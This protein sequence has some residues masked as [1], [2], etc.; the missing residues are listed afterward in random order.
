MT[1]PYVI[2]LWSPNPISP[3][4]RM[5]I[6]SWEKAINLRLKLRQRAFC[7]LSAALAV[8]CGGPRVTGEWARGAGG[9]EAG[10]RGV[11]PAPLA[12]GDRPAAPSPPGLRGHSA[13]Q[14]AARPPA[15]PPSRPYLSLLPPSSAALTYSIS[16]CLPRIRFP[17]RLA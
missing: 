15:L 4:R 2:R 8:S 14:P 11:N 16:S 9:R 1:P 13:R 5:N 12:T 17:F 7:L 10:G 6:S 3:T